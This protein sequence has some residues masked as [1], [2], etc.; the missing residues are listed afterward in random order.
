MGSRWA[1]V[2][3]GWSA[4]AFAILAAAVS[5]TLA[6]G[7][8][9][10]PFALMVSLVIAG[11]VCTALTGR[12]LSRARLAASVAVSQALF[13]GLFS[14]LGTPVATRHQMGSMAMDVT[15]G[16]HSATTMWAGH[17]VAALVTI[18]AFT[19]AEAAFW[20]IATTATLFFARLLALTYSLP[21]RPFTLPRAIELEWQPIAL[22]RLLSPMRHRGPPT[23]LSA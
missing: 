17:A 4:A 20:G 18:V 22:T 5:H 8:A 14:A 2:A 13:H 6:G 3:R 19:Y 23:A 10:T 16:G 1:R 9:P 11:V 15:T 21:P 7:N 12:R